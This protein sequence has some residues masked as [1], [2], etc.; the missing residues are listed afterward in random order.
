VSPTPRAA[1]LVAVI[2]LSVLAVGPA[3]AAVA[4]LALAAALVVDAVAARRAPAA[5]RDLPHT[6]SRGHP[7]RLSVALAGPGATRVRVRQAAVPD[8]DVAPREQ[9]GGLAATVTPRR[10]GQHVLPPAALRVRGPLGLASWDHA[11]GGTH[12]LRVL[13]DVP[14]ARRLALAVREGRFHEPGRRPRGPV[15]LGTDFERIRDYLPDDD[16]RHVNWK[17]TAR[18]GR[19]M[20][21]VLRL[22]QERELIV[23][24]DTGR[25]MA[26]PLADRT[27]LDATLDAATAVGLVADELGDRCGVVAYA[28]E[29]R[30]VLTPRRDG[31]HALIRACFDLEPVAVESAPELAFQEVAGRKRSLVLVLTDLVDESAARSLLSAV[32]VLARRHALVIAGVADPDL[33]EL[34][35]REPASEQDVLTTS[36]AV[37]VSRA[38]ALAAAR[39]GAMGAEVI[40]APPDELPARCVA[41]YVRAKSRARL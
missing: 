36:V 35:D 40:D 7:A 23:L 32:P 30:R 2:A 39:L 41:A 37:E 11:A 38:R 34:L 24:L 8:L 1:A 4:L 21:N 20:T 29:L 3:P 19:P 5:A 15:G 6:L 14:G 25:L 22:E 26:A 12:E 13:P 10:R 33:R 31:G 17:A 18:M 9:D 16:V 27:R 28:G